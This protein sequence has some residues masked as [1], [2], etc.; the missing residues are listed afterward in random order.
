M[1][2]A[3]LMYP[4]ALLQH[5]T[6]WWD[7]LSLAKQFFYGI[8]L[9]AGLIALILM[10]L[11]LVGLEHHDSIDALDAGDAHDGGGGGIFSIKPLTGF[12]LGFGWAGGF[13][14]EQGLSL[15]AALGC[16]FVSGGLI[17]AL[18]VV[19]FRVI[20]SMRSDG[21]MRIADTIGAVGT[22]YVTLPP[23]KASGGQVI[24]NFSGRQETFAALSTASDALP[25]GAKI[26]VL[27]VVDSR[28]LLV[29]P[30]L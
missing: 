2:G 4:I 24:V 23:A 5:L 11:S 27:A 8:G 17:M 10:V 15:M 9:V 25:G 20:L 13:A 28:T 30:L 16:A 26:K 19:M 7:A 3:S 1:L 21:T 14:L 12:F 22:V 6:G 18:I 29:E